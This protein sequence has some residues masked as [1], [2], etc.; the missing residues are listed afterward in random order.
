M[1]PKLYWHDDITP[2]LVGVRSAVDVAT[3]MPPTGHASGAAVV[4]V[5]IAFTVLAVVAVALRLS[6]RFTLSRNAGYED[7]FISLA[8]ILTIGLAVCTCLE[9]DFGM[10]RHQSTLTPVEGTHL[11]KTL[12]AS[13]VLYNTGLSITKLSILLQYLRLF[14]QRGFLIACYTTIAIVSAYCCWTFWSTIFLCIPVPA[15]WDPTI[16]NAKCLNREAVWFANAA[17]NIFTDITITVLPLPM[18]GQ[19][20]VAKNVKIGLMVVL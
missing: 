15:F 18:L 13:I 16:T 1:S 12:Y 19:L 3:T 2:V 4:G 17:I 14:P 8:A 6:T 20:H 9:V 10:G 7:G 5:T 11:L